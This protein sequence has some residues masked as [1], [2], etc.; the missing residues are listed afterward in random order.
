M[1]SN[2]HPKQPKTSLDYLKKLDDAIC[3]LG[4]SVTSETP[5]PTGGSC[6]NPT[7]IEACKPLEVIITDPNVIEVSPS[8]EWSALFDGLG[9]QITESI[10]AQTQELVDTITQACEEKLE[11]LSSIAD[12]NEALLDLL[13]NGSINV[14]A[15]Q[16][17]E[18]E[19]TVT[20]GEIDLHPNTVNAI[21]NAIAD[22]LE[23]LTV[24]IGN[25]P[26]EV[27]VTNEDGEL[28][29]SLSQDSLDA[30]EDINVTITGQDGDPIEVTGTIN[31]GDP[32]TVD[33]TGI[34]DALNG[35]EV[36]TGLEDFL[37]D[38]TLN[39]SL[40]GEELNVN[41][42]SL[43][44]LLADIQVLLDEQV[45]VDYERVDAC[46][47]DAKGNVIPLTG[48]FTERKYSN[49]GSLINSTTVL[50]QLQPDGTWS[51]YTLGAGEVVGAC[52]VEE[53][54]ST[55]CWKSK[56][57]EGGLDNTFTS[58]KHTNQ[59]F[60]VLFSD[61]TN[62]TFN[63]ASATNWSNQVQQ[64]A[65]GLGS[66]MPWAEDTN[67][68]CINGCGDLTE[69]VVPLPLMFARYAGFR[70]CPGDP[71][72]VN[73]SYTSDQAEKS[74]DLVLQFVETETFYWDRCSKCGDP[75]DVIWTNALTGE[76]SE[77]V[78]PCAI[79]CCDDFKETPTT[80]CQFFP[81]V[82]GCD[83][84]T[85]PPTPIARVSKDC[86]NGIENSYLIDDGD[87]GFEDYALVG[88]FT[89]CTSG[90]VVPEEEPD[91]GLEDKI[92]ELID[93]I[94]ELIGDSDDKCPCDECGSEHNFEY[95]NANNTTDIGF[96]SSP[97][98]M[99][100]ELGS[101]DN[102]EGANQ[103]TDNILACIDD[104]ATACIDI[105]DA[106][107][108][109]FQFNA[110]SYTDTSDDDSTSYLFSGEGTADIVG[111]LA[112]ATLTCKCN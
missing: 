60:E 71:V 10:D 79:P 27:V 37:S 59:V 23:G 47:L 43:E 1:A 65:D 66:I 32:I 78:P 85:E 5:D 34:Q 98:A 54:Y 31:I 15:T 44:E 95:Q 58:F 21:A 91:T 104:G 73:V 88:Q 24:E 53:E 99:K 20:G 110:T 52:P 97:T 72:P 106:E 75:T 9:N 48:V 69:P 40:N 25:T 101:G 105:T 11:V 86:G 56:F 77:E 68:Y 2:N 87:G 62:N 93:K 4:E 94:D 112:S 81:P 57:V 12:S 51:E 42:D 102:P 7:F 103:L 36:E 64:M 41:F 16:D 49:S 109:N 61:G 39:V 70:T 26:L 96:S 14:V 82:D 83:N 17:G 45:R 3:C 84:G 100:W 108:N 30:L 13:Q 28:V 38:A 67:S 18:W 22:A 29:V 107:G 33:W 76:V 55:S 35:L 74:V 50:S 6:D 80:N 89:S 46:I 8:D 111:K 19:V 92:C 63:I 90:E